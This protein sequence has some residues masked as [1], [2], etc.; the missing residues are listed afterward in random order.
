[1]YRKIYNTLF[2]LGVLFLMCFCTKSIG[3]IPAGEPTVQ[4]CEPKYSSDIQPIIAEKC[5]TENCHLAGF[6]FGDFS[7]KEEL[8][9]RIDNGK[10]RT[11]VFEA[12][13]MPPANVIDLTE[14]EYSLLKCW[15]ENGAIFN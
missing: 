13:L 6:P 8:K 7:L 14:Q 15:M 5:G 11:L 4:I 2:F 3:K 10:L 1:M 9:K 12:G